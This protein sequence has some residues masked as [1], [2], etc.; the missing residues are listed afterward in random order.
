MNGTEN[1][2]FMQNEQLLICGVLE[3]HI[4][5]CCQLSAMLEE[6]I[7]FKLQDDSSTTKEKWRSVWIFLNVKQGDENVGQRD[8]GQ[9]SMPV[10][11]F[12]SQDKEKESSAA[13][14][15]HIGK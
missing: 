13:S 2:L 12:K 11:E 1:N 9:A 7:H 15:N 4:R 14:L 6:G 8:T 5:G 10:D 3:H